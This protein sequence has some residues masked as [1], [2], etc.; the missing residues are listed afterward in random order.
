VNGQPA[1]LG[2]L[3]IPIPG[4]EH[5]AHVNALRAALPGLGM[6][7]ASSY[8]NTV[9]DAYPAA[10]AVRGV[11]YVKDTA[12]GE[13]MVSKIAQDTGLS[14]GTV[15]A[16]L[17]TLQALA[18]KGTL[19]AATYNPGKFSLSAKVKTAVKSAAGTA[20]KAV[21]STVE[22]VVPESLQTAGSGLAEGVA[23]LGDIARM[24]PLLVLVGGGL[25]L[26]NT[27]GK[28]GRRA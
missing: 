21:K 24:L 3:Y 1:P 9:L 15:K 5:T 23:G 6:Q 2:A 7:D 11:P 22:T 19:S 26:Y 17:N 13:W 4:T 10:S 25:Y 28:K 16:V 18:A 27:Y 14:F 12:A 8:I 20:K